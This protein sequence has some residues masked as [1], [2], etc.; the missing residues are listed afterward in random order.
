VSRREEAA[1]HLP[2]ARVVAD[3]R[4]HV[5]FLLQRR[6]H[7]LAHL[8]VVEGRV[9]VVHAE[10]ADVAERIGDVDHHVPIAAQHRHQVGDRVLPPVDSPF[11]NAAA[12][13]AGRA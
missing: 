6:H 5:V 2:E 11:C 10:G 9:Q 7:G 12:A 3:Q 1:H 8:R 4:A 13:V